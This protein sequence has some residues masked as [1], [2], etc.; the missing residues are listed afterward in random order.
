MRQVVVAGA[1]VVLVVRG[2][3]PYESMMPYNDELLARTIARCPVPVVT[4]IGHEPDNFIADMVADARCSTPTGAAETVAPSLDEVDLALDS[5]AATIS[6]SV[7]GQTRRCARVWIFSTAPCRRL[8][9]ACYRATASSSIVVRCCRRFESRS[10][11]ST[12]R[13]VRST[14]SPSV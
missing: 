6:S 9:R 3:G 1:E 11:F 2:E 5:A 8:K 7:A 14:I 4:G 10:A 13:R 12:P